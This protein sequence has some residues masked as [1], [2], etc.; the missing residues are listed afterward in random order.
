MSADSERLSAPVSVVVA[1]IEAVS[2]ALMAD[3][4]SS[5]LAPEQGDLCY[6]N[7]DQLHRGRD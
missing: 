5:G 2:I 3:L 1:N 4:L 7:G 6:S